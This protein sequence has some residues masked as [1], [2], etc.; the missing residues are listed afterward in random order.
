MDKKVEGTEVIIKGV[1]PCARNGDTKRRMGDD[2]K[3]WRSKGC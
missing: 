3:H 1:D 2:R